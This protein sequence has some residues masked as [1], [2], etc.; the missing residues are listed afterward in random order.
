MPMDVVTGTNRYVGYLC[1]PILPFDIDWL[2]FLVWVGKLVSGEFMGLIFFEFS[3]TCYAYFSWI[4]F[5]VF[6]FIK[7]SLWAGVR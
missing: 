2:G 6:V 3:G 5:G 7:G 1:M 4:R